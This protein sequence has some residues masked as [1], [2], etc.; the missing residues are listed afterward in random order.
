MTDHQTVEE[1]A[2]ARFHARQG[3]NCLQ[4]LSE[5]NQECNQSVEDYLAGHAGA[6]EA[7]EETRR[8]IIS[9]MTGP[10]SN[11]LLDLAASSKVAP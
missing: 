6:L 1:R 7:I 4:V 11:L 9:I 2:R 3:C 10:V 8:K 5:H